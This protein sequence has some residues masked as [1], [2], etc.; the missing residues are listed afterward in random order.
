MEFQVNSDL[1][2]SDR[3]TYSAVD[4]FGDLGGVIELCQL[5]VGLFALKFSQMRLYALITNRLYHL[6]FDSRQLIADL[7][8]SS[9]YIRKRPNGDTEVNVPT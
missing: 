5:T 9:D 4:L 6:S 3:V 7:S 1:K 8:N 2:S